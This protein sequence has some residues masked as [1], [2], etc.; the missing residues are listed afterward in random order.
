MNFTFIEC[1]K[2]CFF[3]QHVKEPTPGK[4]TNNASL[5]DLVLTNNNGFINNVSGKAPLGKSDH[6][7]IE[8]V[9][10]NHPLPSYTEM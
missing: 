2:D 6:S 8:V 3:E 5:L 10:Q 1:I 7:I 9:L 4:G